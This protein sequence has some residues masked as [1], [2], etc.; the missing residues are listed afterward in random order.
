MLIRGFRRCQIK[1]YANRTD[2][3]FHHSVTNTPG[4]PELGHL[5][6]APIVTSTGAAPA[7]QC[8]TG[9]GRV[10]RRSETGPPPASA[11]RSQRVWAAAG[12]PVRL[13]DGRGGRLQIQMAT[14]S[15]TSLGPQG[16]AT[17]PPPRKLNSTQV[18]GGCHHSTMR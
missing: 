16:S 13:L 17:N 9:W 3:N 4:A 11:A 12:W 8:R 14:F 5:P 10:L 18:G 7:F 15:L 2:N 6:C 1:V